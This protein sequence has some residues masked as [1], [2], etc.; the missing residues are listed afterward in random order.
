[1]K[2]ASDDEK[3]ISLESQKWKFGWPKQSAVIST[4]YKT[5]IAVEA[6]NKNDVCFI[7]IFSKF[8]SLVYEKVKEN[9][10][11]W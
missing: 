9:I 4:G 8:P 6:L 5:R 7:Q 2:S 1:M 3:V 10:S 11:H